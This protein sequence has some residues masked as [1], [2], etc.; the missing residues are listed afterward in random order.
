MGVLFSCPVD[1]YD[2][3]EESAAAAA[4]AAAASSS[5]SG[6]PAAILKALGSGKLLIEGSLSF[7][8]DQQMSPTS[9]LHV[10]TEIS[11]K[12]AGDIAAPREM[13][14]AEEDDEFWG[15]L[16][17]ITSESYPKNTVSDDSEDR[18]AEAEE[19]IHSQMPR[20]SD[21]PTCAEIDGCDEPATT[22]RLKKRN[23]GILNFD[24]DS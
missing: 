24:T 10:E 6:K 21:E 9:L 14:P 2:A 19:T 23:D 18:A 11:I 15:S 22:R 12:P 5:G 8:R 7:K 20:V 4:A 13:S 1:D 16:K 17:R 3:L